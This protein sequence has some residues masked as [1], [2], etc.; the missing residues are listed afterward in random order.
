MS[1]SSVASSNIISILII[2]S[3]VIY[4]LVRQFM[5]QQ[6]TQRTVRMPLILG[7]VLGALF[8]AQRP[9]VVALVA[10][11]AGLLF[12][13]ATGAIGGALIRIWRAADGAVYR[14]GGWQYLLVLLVFIA[15]R[16]AV[17]LALHSF[18]SQGTLND[19]LLAGLV[20]NYLAR[21][22]VIVLR[23]LPLV[24]NHFEALP[25]RAR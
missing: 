6:V 19:A 22:G 23:A 14:R 15:V 3:L 16:V 12:G 9:T 25:S 2:I 11:V 8:V 10:V 21:A 24:G 17:D 18:V 13:G 4:L 20:G 7:A 1:P 5:T